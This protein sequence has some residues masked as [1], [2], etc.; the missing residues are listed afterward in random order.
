MQSSQNE[1]LIEV[2]ADES[3]W[4]EKKQITI[5]QGDTK[6]I[7]GNEIIKSE[8]ANFLQTEDRARLSGSVQY[9][10]DGIEVKAP[11]AEYNT[12]EGRTDFISPKYNYPS[13]DISG[14]AR[15]GVRLKNK[16]M[17]LK[18]STYTTC[19]FLNPDWN[20]ISKSTELDFDKGV[21]TGKNVF[22]SI[23]GVPVFIR[24]I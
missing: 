9:N 24:R 3:Y 19:D 1:E 17:F 2:E 14:K 21:G 18:N 12:K 5:L 8:L 10:A 4:D 22:V 20:L 16:K 15:Y 7:R 23:R 13:L 11:Y 6:I